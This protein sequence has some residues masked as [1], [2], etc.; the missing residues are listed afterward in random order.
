M[1]DDENAKQICEKVEQSYQIIGRKWVALII[2]TLMEEPK[3]FS[4][5][6]AYIPDLS[7]RVLNERMKEL[8]EEGLVVRH[9]V[10]ERPVRTEY[11]L[12]RKGTEL[13]RALSSVERWADKW[14]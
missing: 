9:V 1:S 6:H 7:K 5:I 3:R 12:S 11:M 2:H 13:G 14:L 8:E 4:E 10:T